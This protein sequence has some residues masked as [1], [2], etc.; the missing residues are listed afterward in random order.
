MP[1]AGAGTRRSRRSAAPA[2]PPGRWAARVSTSS[3]SGRPSSAR[4]ASTASPGATGSRFACAATA[5]ASCWR[6]RCQCSG[7]ASQ[8]PLTGGGRARSPIADAAPARSS[9]C[10]RS[11]SAAAGG[12]GH[13]DSS[14]SAAAA[15]PL[16]RSRG[17]DTSSTVAPKVGRPAGPVRRGP[18]IAEQQPVADVQR[19]RVIQAQPGDLAAQH[20]DPGDGPRRADVHG[21]LGRQPQ[22][23]RRLPVRRPGPRQP[24]VDHAGHRPLP[25]LDQRH[26]AAQLPRADA[27]QVQRHPGH[28]ADL[29]GG[30]AKRLHAPDPQR[31]QGRREHQLIPGVDGPGLQRAGDHGPAALD[32]EHPVQPQPDPVARVGFRQPGREP[33]QRGRQLGQALPGDGAD[34][35]GC[36]AAQAGLRDLPRG[37]LPARARDRPGRIA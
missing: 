22:C 17:G 5:A 10:L 29:A 6:S 35:D 27:A 1:S 19:Q 23:A 25:G 9:R 20:P 33:A 8:S 32:R 2:R 37:L 13:A 12:S 21:E 11:T 34:P 31:A 3:R 18:G 26:A 7:S 15:A 28:A 14:R 36:P 24:D 4:A 30:R 16:P